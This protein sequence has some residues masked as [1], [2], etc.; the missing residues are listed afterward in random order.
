MIK[1]H[2]C[3]CSN[4][5][6]LRKFNVSGKIYGFEL[7]EYQNFDIDSSLDFIIENI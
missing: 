5:I 6:L 3:I 7:K 2:Q 4:L 1:W